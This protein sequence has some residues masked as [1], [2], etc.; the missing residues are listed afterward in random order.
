MSTEIVYGWHVVAALLS[1]RP[2][3]VKRIVIGAQRQ[4][5]R[6]LKLKELAPSFAFEFKTAKELDAWLPDVVHQ[7]VIAYV[8]PARGLNENELM[9][10]LDGLS[11]PAFLL[12][13]DGVTDPHNLGACLRTADA[14][15]VDAVIIPKDRAA[16]LSAI[17]RK[18]SAGASETVKLVAVTNL[19][20]CLGELRSRGIWVVG[21]TG[22]S[23]RSLYASDLTGA[24]A[25][26]MGA[27]GKGMRRLT[28]ENCDFCVNLPMHGSVESLNV[29]VAT[30]IMLYEAKRQRLASRS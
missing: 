9:D 6:F 16:S 25:I 5:Q 30:G 27:E 4:D 28:Q 24:L 1:N 8:L 13:L 17:V 2:D 26:V 19:A 22:E 3:A 18:V 15:G 23:E 10:M 29:S 20:R 12:V 14:A 21:T 7:G 11:R